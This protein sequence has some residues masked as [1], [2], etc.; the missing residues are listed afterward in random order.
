MVTIQS[1]YHTSDPRPALRAVRVPALVV[2]GECDRIRPEIAREY[3]EILPN[4]SLVTVDGA[5]HSVAGSPEFA[6]ILEDFLLNAEIL[7]TANVSLY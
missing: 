2:R 3:A 4:A 6:A 7:D 5:A 1:Q